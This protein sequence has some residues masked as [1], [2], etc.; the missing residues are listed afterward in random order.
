MIYVD[1]VWAV[2]CDG[3]WHTAQDIATRV[4][5]SP[6]RVVEVLE[7]LVK[8]GFALTD[9]QGR[10]RVFMNLDGPSPSEA[11]L[12]LSSVLELGVGS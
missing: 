3:R 7:F 8:Y 12:A 5:S 9:V 1:A 11:A 2:A 6:A 10:S 4:H